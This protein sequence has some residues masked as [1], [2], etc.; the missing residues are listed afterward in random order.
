MTMIPQRSATDETTSMKTSTALKSFTTH[1]VAMLLWLTLRRCQSWS[2]AN[3][4]K[5]HRTGSD[6][7][8]LPVFC[9]NA[10]SSV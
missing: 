5:R 9:G 4:A 3:Q 2:L 8:S 1:S 6:N 7:D 10:A